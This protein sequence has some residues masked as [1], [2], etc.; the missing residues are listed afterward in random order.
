MQ[1]A[2]VLV[3]TASFAGIMLGAASARAQDEG[4][5]LAWSAPAGCPTRDEVRT[6]TLR[7]VDRGKML[8]GTLNAEASVEQLGPQS[9]RVRLRT[10]RGDQAGE[11]EIEGPTCAGVAD[12]TAV[13]LAL[14]LVPPTTIAAPDEP[15][16]APT[17][18]AAPPTPPTAPSKN[19][20]TSAARERHTVAVGVA[21]VGDVGELPKPGVGGALDLAWTPGRLRLEAEGRILGGQTEHVSGRAAG[22]DFSLKSIG[23]R[24]C[25][26]VVSQTSFDVA[27]CLGMTAQLMGATGRNADENLTVSK[28]W[29]SFE[30]GALGRVFLANWFAFR[31]RVEAVVPFFRPSFVVEGQ[32]LVFRPPTI[33][34]AGFLGA[35]VLFL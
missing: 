3:A 34:A 7:G 29:P 18:P 6:A 22:A 31:A 12:A 25:F 1:C 21:V 24:A 26:V 13:V 27:P 15:P 30:G 32:G 19:K 4:L 23:G 11:R 8:P 10:R 17:P 5:R 2:R 14:A 9:W 16:S 28:A 35:E 20:Q 33:G